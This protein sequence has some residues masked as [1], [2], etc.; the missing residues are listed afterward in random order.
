M[1]R[2]A[3]TVLHRSEWDRLHRRKDD[4]KQLL[5]DEREAY[6]QRLV[7]ISQSWIK[8]WPDTVQVSNN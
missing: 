5:S 8:T 3:Y 4:K 7:D 2:K 1:G 6:F